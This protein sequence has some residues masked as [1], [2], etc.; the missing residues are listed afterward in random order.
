M[1][2]SLK[3]GLLGL[4][5]I[6]IALYGCG[7][8]V[9]EAQI[10]EPSTQQYGVLMGKVLSTAGTSLDAVTVTIASTSAA[11]NAQGWF[12]ISNLTASARE[13]VTF[14]KTGYATTQRIARIYTG[15]AT[16]LDVRMGET[17]STTS[18]SG[19]AGGSASATT[20]TGLTAS[21]S[22]PASA[23]AD[24][25]GAAYTGSADVTLTPF[26]PS[27]NNELAAFPGEFEG[28]DNSSDTV[29]IKTY[30]FMNVGVMGGSEPLVLAAGAAATITIPVPLDSTSE[31]PSTCPL[32][33]F[34]T[35]DGK[36]KQEGTGT[37]NSSLG[38]YVGTVTH[39]STWNYDVEYTRAYISGR[40][41]D[42][43]G[44]P[45]QGAEITCRGDGWMWMEW[46]SGD[47]VTGSDG[48]FTRIPVE[49]GVIF[50]YWAQKGGKISATD[51][52]PLALSADELLDVGDIELDSPL[53]QFTLTWGQN[54]VDLDSHLTI[55]AT[56]SATQRG[57]LWY[58][59]TVDD[60]YSNLAGQYPYAILDTDDT[61]S[62]GPEVT[63]IYKLY[64]GTYRF[65]I[66]HY[67]G[68]S[69]ISNSNANINLIVAGGGRSGIYNFTPP[70]GA[71]AEKDVWRVCDIVVDSSGNISSVTAL[72]DLL[73]NI[74]SSSSGEDFS[75]DG[76]ATYD[77]PAAGMSVQSAKAKK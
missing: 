70:S 18:I 66:H 71:T 41:V 68:T 50:Q 12:A 4:I 19:A 47:T 72:G 63:S 40:V 8:A 14:S 34:D 59:Y 37:Y 32:W 46:E 54:P 30:G 48:R 29:P 43:N 61:S 17:G 6:G 20:S 26:D 74:E 44:N 10:T 15:E 51:S 73:T 69:N 25:T 24:G 65:S 75:P 31:A 13:I 60:G 49:T 53:V 9:K 64:E 42:S 55:P 38:A 52:N 33:Y 28:E 76:E 16:F 22:I 21:V 39:F 5:V 27:L 3:F 35:T 23:L 45:V 67:S 7:R 56:S 36:W 11:T 1:K 77:G 57:H 2:R 58:N 62:Y